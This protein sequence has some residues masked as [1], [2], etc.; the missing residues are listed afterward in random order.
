MLDG[1]EWTCLHLLCIASITGTSCSPLRHVLA[2]GCWRTRFVLMKRYYGLLGGHMSAC[3]A[4]R[5]KDAD[6]SG[7]PWLLAAG[8]FSYDP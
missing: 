1:T 5:G 7:L 4:I 2:V 8:I 3:G 6:P